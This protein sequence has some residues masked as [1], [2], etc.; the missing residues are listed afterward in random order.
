M[1]C[2]PTSI[3]LMLFV[4]ANHKKAARREVED[5]HEQQHAK[6]YFDAGRCFHLVILDLPG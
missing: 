3:P 1:T 5:S 4:G 6:H 2:G